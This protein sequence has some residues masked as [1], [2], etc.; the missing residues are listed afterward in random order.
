[1]ERF[2]GVR[3]IEQP[4]TVTAPSIARS[5]ITIAFGTAPIHQVDGKPNT[6]V[7]AYS[8]DEA[9]SA[10][11]Y[12][13]DWEKY[14]LCEVVYSHFKLY[15]VAPLLL[16]NVL[17]PEAHQTAVD[18]QEYTIENWQIVL[19]GDAIASSIVVTSDDTE[20]VAGT[21]YDVFY[22][23][24]NCIIETLAGGA[25]EA[26]ELTAVTVSYNAVSFER[27]ELVDDVIGGYNVRTGI[28]TGIELMDAAYSAS[29]V[30]PDI[31]IAPGFSQYPEVAAVMAAKTMYSTIF[32]ACCVCDLDTENTTSYQDVVKLKENS[33]S[34]KN[35]K[36]ILCWPKLKLEDLTFHYST[37]LAGQMCA[38]DSDNDN[39]PSDVASNR[40]L[41]A[42]G[43]V[44]ADG[45]EILLDLTQA[46]YLR[47]NGIVTAYNF[48]NGFTSWGVYNACW[49]K[50]TDPKDMFISISRMFGYIANTAIV[51]LWRK[52]DQKLTPRYVES[53]VDEL[54]MWINTL[55]SAGHMHGARCEYHSNEN[56]DEDIMNGIVRLHIYMAPP[57]PGQEIDLLLEYDASYVTAAFSAGS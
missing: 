56:P 21:D 43:A 13:D 28:S 44:L 52:I 38:V 30:L 5:G 7:T 27:S 26:A 48:V 19:T 8:Y 29:G 12:S 39:I 53:I 15:G 49:P 36:Q 16:V 32:R 9:V 50:N 6:I 54:N 17:D 47:G 37:Q 34:F 40:T 2:Y 18:A 55:T 14:T 4:T 33:A 11:G 23:D 45:T 46:N 41:Q 31:M 24:G 1:M 20:F 57:T 51:T 3:A 25:I 42:D 10:L 35:K 22:S